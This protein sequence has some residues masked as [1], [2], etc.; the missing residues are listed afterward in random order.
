[1]VVLLGGT[2]VYNGSLQLPG[3]HAERLLAHSSL[4]ASP[5][6]ARS[7]LLPSGAELE[8][9]FHDLPAGTP[10]QN[11]RLRM[12]PPPAGNLKEGLLQP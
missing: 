6:L 10:R 12:S 9:A 11:A 5:R 3:V 7:P 1:M 4:K 2:A 8:R